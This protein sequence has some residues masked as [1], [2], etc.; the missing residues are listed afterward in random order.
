MTSLQADEAFVEHYQFSHDPFTPR[1]PGFKFFPAQRKPVLAQLHQLARYSA[2]MLVVTGPLGSGKTLLRQALVASSNKQSVVSVV[3]SGRQ[4]GSSAALLRHFSQGLGGSSQDVDGLLGQVARLNQVGQEVYLLV[5][6]AERLQDEALATLRALATGD[7]DGRAHVFLFAETELLA[8]LEAA[9][10]ADSCQVQELQ[11][12]GLEETRAYL[13]QRLE[14]AG[15]GVELLDDAQ[16]EEIHVESGGWPG[17]INRVARDA[18]IEAMLAE[19]QPEALGGRGMSLPKKHLLALGVVAAGVALALVMKGQDPEGTPVAADSPAPS[20]QVATA[21]GGTASANAGGPSIQFAGDSKP[22]PL[23]LA[24]QGQPVPRE[25]LARAAGQ[26]GVE[27]LDASNAAMPASVPPVTA[28]TTAPSVAVAESSA[29]STAQVA[30]AAAPLAVVQ[31]AQA[32]VSAA[33]P[34]KP[35]LAAAPVVEAARKPAAVAVKPAVPEVR[36][37]APVASAP[38]PAAGS[39]GWYLSQP[40]GQYTLQLLGTASEGAAQAMVRDGGGEYR[41][42][43]KLHQGKP[44]YVVTYGRFSSPEAAKSALG[45]LPSRLQAGKPW[46]RTFASIQQ[47]IRQAGR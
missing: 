27:E 34:P 19:R 42:F 12:Y 3:V 37:A 20:G 28:T 4:A 31:P 35:V 16:L 23:P 18:L 41:Y 32:A 39:S 9:G 25:P 36:P 1:V 15:Q 29:A 5:D 46:P 26:A 40:V 47:E 38:A 43:R 8:R 22:L 14:G 44:L 30:P 33:T 21:P 24:G 17:A 2:L 10:L 45:G 13:A 7:S 6:D 11:P